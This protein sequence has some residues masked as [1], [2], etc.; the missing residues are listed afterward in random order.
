MTLDGLPLAL[1]NGI[2]VVGVVLIVGWLVWTGRLVPKSI[3]EARVVDLK[4]Q[5]ADERHEK[6]EW[7]TEARIKDQTITELNQQNEAMLRA[8]GPTLT[9]FLHSLRASG[10]GNHDRGDQP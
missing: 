2:G 3:H 1:A 10:V 6:G 4:E 8:F 9:D 7:R 5:V